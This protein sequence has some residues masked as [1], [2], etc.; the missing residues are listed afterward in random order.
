[1]Y[2]WYSMNIY[3]IG[4]LKKIKNIDFK[5]LENMPLLFRWFEI[6]DR[7]EKI[8]NNIYLA[9]NKNG[10][11]RIIHDGFSLFL[12][13][14][15]DDKFNDQHFKPTYC[16]TSAKGYKVSDK[17]ELFIVLPI[18]NFNAIQSQIFKDSIEISSYGL[19]QKLQ[20][21]DKPYHAKALKSAFD[22]Y[23]LSDP[24]YENIN[25][26]MLLKYRPHMLNSLSKI[27]LNTYREVT[28]QNIHKG[29]VLLYVEKYILVKYNY[30]YDVKFNQVDD[31]EKYIAQFSHT[32]QALLN[33]LLSETELFC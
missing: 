19:I 21:I 9:H 3:E 5:K 31:F 33:K 28:M 15:I 17:A 25:I 13:D 12:Y 7:V 29:E 2:G 6:N 23:S 32:Y 30:V 24:R 22:D 4:L 8:E 10:S 1:M 14:L 11:K 16:A 27:I 26:S 18:G 20:M